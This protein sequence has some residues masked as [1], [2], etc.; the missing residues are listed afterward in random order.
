MRRLS[1]ITQWCDVSVVSADITDE[2]YADDYSLWRLVGDGEMFFCLLIGKAGEEPVIFCPNLEDEIITREDLEVIDRN[3]SEVWLK[4]ESAYACAEA[5]AD[6]LLQAL[7]KSSWDGYPRHSNNFYYFSSI[8]TL[9]RIP[10][11]DAEEEIWALG[12]GTRDYFITED[13]TVPAGL[14][15]FFGPGKVIIS[16][17]AVVN[18]DKDASLFYYEMD[19]Q[20]VIQ[21]EGSLV[22]SRPEE[23]V[24]VLLKI[25]GGAILNNG[26]LSYYNVDDLSRIQNLEDGTVYSEESE[27]TVDP[28]EAGKSEKPEA[29]K[30]LPL[31]LRLQRIFLRLQYFVRHLFRGEWLSGNLLPAIAVLLALFTVIRKGKRKKA[32][33]DPV[34]AKRTEQSR[35]SGF[36]ADASLSE[37]QQRRIAHLDDWLKSG[38]IDRKEYQV[39]KARY[40]KK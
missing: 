19:V 40:Q 4:E 1:R 25:G 33:A 21:N 16:P 11:L 26:W 12:G 30:S 22:Q 23:G 27:S 39:L 36:S 20:G 18:I 24:P 32:D 34:P 2:E 13:L 7:E 17:E 38:L 29:Q 8:D 15:V 31:S 14:T 28:Q 6:S 10:V 5:F 35:A 37:D 9:R 3:A